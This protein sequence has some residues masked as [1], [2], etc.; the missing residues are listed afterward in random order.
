[1]GEQVSKQKQIRPIEDYILKGF[2][3]RFTEVFGCMS[4]LIAAED[5][6]VALEAA[7]EG[8]TPVV[9]YAFLKPT[10]FA[11]NTNSYNRRALARHGLVILK[12]EGITHK[13]KLTPVVFD[14]EVEYITDRFQGYKNSA[15]SFSRRWMMTLSQ[16]H[17]RFAF[18]YGNV[19]FNIAD[20]TMQESVPITPRGNPV[21]NVTQYSILTSVQIK[22]YVSEP[23]L[24]ESSTIQEMEV[25]IGVGSIGGKIVSTQFIS[26]DELRVTNK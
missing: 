10:S 6:A 2:Q 23:M 26:F 1:M 25:G 18:Q 19:Q 4:I 3:E 9:P 5:K 8:Q 11:T 20:I 17:L 21:E 13:V 14:I 7:F 15:M 24:M 22:G 12:H 16:N